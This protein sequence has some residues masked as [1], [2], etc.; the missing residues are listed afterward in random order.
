MDIV[1]FVKCKFIVKTADGLQIPPFKDKCRKSDVILYG[2]S[3]VHE[4][5]SVAAYKDKGDILTC[6]RELHLLEQSLRGK[7]DG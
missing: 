2:T 1:F 4:T 3:T 5:R 6:T 7:K